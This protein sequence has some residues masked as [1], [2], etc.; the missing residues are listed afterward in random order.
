MLDDL[1]LLEAVLAP[2]IAD[3]V[4][5]HSIAR[6]AGDVGVRGQERVGVTCPR[7]RGE[8]QEPVL[9]AAL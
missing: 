6:G 3:P 2:S 9:E 7:G 5:E 1:H 4:G 8:R